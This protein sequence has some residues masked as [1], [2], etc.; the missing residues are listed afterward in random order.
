M[1]SQNTWYPNLDEPITFGDFSECPFYKWNKPTVCRMLEWV[2]ITYLSAVAW[3]ENI[4]MLHVGI[5]VRL[6]CKLGRAP[7]REINT[8][9][10]S[11]KQQHINFQRR[12]HFT[13]LLKFFLS[14]PVCG[15]GRILPDRC[16]ACLLPLLRPK[17]SSKSRMSS[18]EE[19]FVG[20]IG[21]CNFIRCCDGGSS[22]SHIK[23]AIV[24]RD[25]TPNSTNIGDFT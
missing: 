21:S 23:V 7:K 25:E 1:V 20:L 15:C 24:N 13:H 11:K 22:L 8:Q 4:L 17:R 5:R 18:S 16:V 12:F 14:I 9:P 6:A 2:L 19:L 3:K 10:R